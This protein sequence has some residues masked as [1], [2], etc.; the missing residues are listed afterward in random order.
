MFF[1][2]LEVVEAEGED[3]EDDLKEDFGPVFFVVFV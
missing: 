1:M 2:L 3:L